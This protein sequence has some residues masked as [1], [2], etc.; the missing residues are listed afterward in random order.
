MN[1]YIVLIWDIENQTYLKPE[2]FTSKS[3][4]FKFA[5][6]TRNTGDGYEYSAQVYEWLP[7]GLN[8]QPLE[9]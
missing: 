4:A 6:E 3:K 9:K 8:G 1:P 2:S 5:E 7:T